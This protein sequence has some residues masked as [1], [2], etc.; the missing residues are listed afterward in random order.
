M[1]SPRNSRAKLLSSS[2]DRS[3][4]VELARRLHDG[5]AQELIALGY[6]LDGLIGRGD[7]DAQLRSE[8]RQLR[9]KMI[10]L[11]TSF[12][13]EI[14]LLRRLTFT[15]LEEAISELFP[16]PKLSLPKIPLP[17]E[18]EDSLARAILEMARN[19][20]RHSGS[21]DFSVTHQV[22]ENR[23]E[24]LVGDN[25]RGKISLKER[26]FGLASIQELLDRASADFSLESDRNGNR[27]RIGLSL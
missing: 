11:T 20:A 1:S 3:E 15:Q 2:P 22:L 23:L 10:D 4:R 5:L 24:I 25:G 18:V 6:A 12:R 21:Y 26:S 7:V 14:Y 27:Y 9:L 17:D 13:D 16:K 8:L 19:S